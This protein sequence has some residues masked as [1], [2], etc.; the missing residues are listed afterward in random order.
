MRG[1]AASGDPRASG[2]IVLM[3]FGSAAEKGA[4]SAMGTPLAMA[5][6]VLEGAAPTPA[7]DVY[8]LGVVLFRLLTHRWPVDAT[9]LEGLRQ[10]HKA[11][12]RLALRSARPDLPHELVAAVERALESDPARRFA[13]AAGMERALSAVVAPPPSV[14]R[15]GVPWRAI[16]V[17]AAL[18]ALAVALWF[19]QR[20]RSRPT[21]APPAA[22]TPVTLASPPAV[23]AVAAP[24]VAVPLDVHATFYRAG[25]AGPEA[26][27]DGDRIA[28]GDRLFLELQSAS[29]LH[30]YVL[31]ADESNHVFVL[32]PLAGRGTR[33]PVPASPGRRLPGRDAGGE[34]D[35]QVTSAGGRESF[36]VI[37]SLLP[38]AAVE[39]VV[40]RF[41]TARA[42]A[43]V[44]YPALDAGALGAVR[45]VG[46]LTRGP[47]GDRADTGAL[48]SLEREL[49]SAP[50]DSVWTRLVVLA[51]PRFP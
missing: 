48:A 33:N 30:V 45:G 43:G 46:G 10:K 29:A 9:T 14:A 16:G 40:H 37:A 51:N 38:V 27:A 2:R 28:P 31:N 36:L 34:L 41:A 5:P 12:D 26:L 47:A 21:N 42:E 25:E 13:D 11:G 24:P 6:E 17:V 4:S 50:R 23:P 1:G 39:R 18:A 35:W 32:F 7:A 19:G 3:D 8:S 44:E 15:R 22:T 20:G 49:R